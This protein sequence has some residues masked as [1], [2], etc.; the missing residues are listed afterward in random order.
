MMEQTLSPEQTL[1]IP[2]TLKAN[3]LIRGEYTLS[4]A[5][6]SITLIDEH[7]KPIRKLDEPFVLEERFMFTVQKAGT[8]SVV[9]EALSNETR[10][11][12]K[13][14][15]PPAETLKQ[16]IP[17]EEILSPTLLNM[18]GVKDTSAFWE[19]I[20]RKGTPLVETSKEG[21]YLLTFLYKGA[22]N[23]VQIMGAPIGD[24]AYMSKMPEN[25]IW[26]KSFIVPKGTRLSYQLA[27]DVPMIK[28][29]PRE[30]R[31]AILATLQA[32]PLNQKPMHSRSDDIYRT[33]STV[34]LPDQRYANWEKTPIEPSG[35]MQHYTLTSSLL[36]NERAVDVY[37]PKAFSKEKTYP[38]LFLFDGKEYQSKVHVPNILDN[39]IAARK[40]PPMIAVFISNPNYRSRA[41]E[42]PCNPLFADFMAKELLPWFQQTI[43][44]HIEAKTTILSGSSYGGLASAYTA[45]RYPDHFG[46]VLSLSGSFWWAEEDAESQWLTREF[47]KTDRLPIKFYLYAGLFETGQSTIDI[48]ESNR[49]LRTV[50]NAKDYPIVYE[51]FAG[52]HDYFSW[53]VT[54]ADGLIHIFNPDTK[55]HP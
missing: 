53:G 21:D 24:I 30:R 27:P 26:Y 5:V 10:F 7:E 40:I 4:T 17:H 45:F 46:N 18:R 54:L 9:I 43:T 55:E 13:L 15:I 28:A 51:E 36:N 31:M 22:K 44:P 33:M 29:E 14:E 37:L 23:N 34:E 49:H 3:D 41:S 2:L 47:A 16:P 38:V 8:Y 1:R 32:D 6:K 20:K 25:D 52:G 11:T 19:A 48:L 12:C 50:L 35:N 42:L 39:L